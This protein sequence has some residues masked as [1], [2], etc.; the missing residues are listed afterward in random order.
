M[1]DKYFS[2]HPKLYY[3]CNATSNWFHHN[4]FECKWINCWV[5][6]I[7]CLAAFD[8]G[9]TQKQCITS[10]KF[11]PKNISSCKSDKNITIRVAKC[12][13]YDGYIRVKILTDLVE[14]FSKTILFVTFIQ[15]KCKNCRHLRFFLRVKFGLKVLLRVKE[16]TFRNS[17][18]DHNLG[19]LKRPN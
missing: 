13:G 17:E 15:F 12:H 11:Y 2:M 10:W 8:P 14:W 16:L 19:L 5:D 3:A 1:E 9:L 6:L 4:H 18:V 7:F